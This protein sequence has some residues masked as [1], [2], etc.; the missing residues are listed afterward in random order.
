MTSTTL[1]VT[2]QLLD[3]LL[4]RTLLLG[5]RADTARRFARLQRRAPAS[6]SGVTP[7]S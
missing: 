1:Y 3:G 6:A 7:S 4:N 5:Y 2:P